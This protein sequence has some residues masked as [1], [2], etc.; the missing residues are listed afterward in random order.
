MTDAT[1][2][3]FFY[4]NCD[5]LDTKREVID[6]VEEYL[7]NVADMKQRVYVVLDE[8]TSVKDSLL[9]VKY[10]VDAGKY[11]N[12][13]YILTGS[14][15]INIKKTGEYPPGRRGH[16]IDITF[17]P[18]G[19]ADFVG[20]LHPEIP[21]HLH[22]ITLEN[23]KARYTEIRQAIDLDVLFDTYLRCGGI[24]KVIE[25]CV[26]TGGIGPET[27]DT[28]KSWIA[29]EIAKQDKKE[30]LCK[31]IFERVL[32]SLSSDV[33]YKSFLQD[34]NIGSHNT[35]HDYLTFMEDAFF[36]QQVYHCDFHQQRVNYRKN[37]KLYFS[38]PFVLWVVDKWI[39]ARSV[40]GFSML[41]NPPQKAQV[42]ENVV[43][44]ELGS[45]FG[46]DIY[47]Y[48][49]KHEVDFVSPG[50]LLEVKYQNKVVPSDYAS[51]LRSNTPLPKWVASKSTLLLESDVSV[52]PVPFLLLAK[53]LLLG[54][55]S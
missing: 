12:I 38:D 25:Q 1:R 23:A 51:L 34:A 40:Q 13:T 43:A 31:L 44:S 24:P 28:Y 3:N 27:F 10:L 5:Y 50:F 54:R 42:V 30:Y 35:V 11:P 32:L 46:Q 7:A 37:K 52:V 53:D 20:L 18:L 4:F 39:H 19:F 55:G 21:S 17:K 41:D 6:L 8:V 2:R 16:G 48:H 15:S 47:Y 36:V 14:S 22:G 49:N 29:S 33:S 45:M 26:N 9:A